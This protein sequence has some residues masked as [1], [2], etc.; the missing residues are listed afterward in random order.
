MSSM[1]HSKDPGDKSAPEESYDHHHHLP[2][3]EAVACAQLYA[4]RRTAGLSVTHSGR[5]KVQEVE[6]HSI[7]LDMFAPVFAQVYLLSLSHHLILETSTSQ[8]SIDQPLLP[9]PRQR[10]AGGPSGGFQ[11]LPIEL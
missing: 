7:G 2:R 9:T 5:G 11:K 3:G 6:D 8:E 1:I 10:Q 4:S